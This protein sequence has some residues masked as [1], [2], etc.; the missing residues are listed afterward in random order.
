MK[1]ITNYEKSITHQHQKWLDQETDLKQEK[2]HQMSNAVSV[3]DKNIAF[4][5]KEKSL[6][7]KKLIIIRGN[8]RIFLI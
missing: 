2:I 3:L 5:L 8:I 7:R 6:E 1:F 4:L